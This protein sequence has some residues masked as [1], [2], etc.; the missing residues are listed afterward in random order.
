MTKRSVVLVHVFFSK[1]W[2]FFLSTLCAILHTAFFLIPLSSCHVATLEYIGTTP[3]NQNWLI[4][5]ISG[6]ANTIYCNVR[7]YVSYQKKAIDFFQNVLC[8]P[9]LL[10]VQHPFFSCEETQNKPFKSNIIYILYYIYGAFQHFP[11]KG[12]SDLTIQTTLAR[13]QPCHASPRSPNVQSVLLP[14]LAQY[15]DPMLRARASL[16]RIIDDDEAKRGGEQHFI[17]WRLHAISSSGL[18]TGFHIPIFPLIVFRTTEP[19]LIFVFKCILKSHDRSIRWRQP[20]TMQRKRFRVI[21]TTSHLWTSPRAMV[22]RAPS[23]GWSN[24]IWF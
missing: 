10:V 19:P 18:H 20:V 2:C 13:H 11:H 1:I 16:Q 14:E 7:S 23:H 5:G 8:H 9:K 4:H 6:D 24:V 17:W 21:W 22:S 15:K 12:S 3:S